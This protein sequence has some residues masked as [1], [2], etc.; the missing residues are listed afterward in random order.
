M[1]CIPEGKGMGAGGNLP[2]VSHSF[3]WSCGPDRTAFPDRIPT[4]PGENPAVFQGS[5][6][7][8]A[9]SLSQ[10]KRSSQ[11]L[12]SLCRTSCCCFPGLRL[13]R[14][15]IRLENT[16]C[17]DKSTWN[18]LL[19]WGRLCPLAELEHRRVWVYF[20]LQGLLGR[21]KW[22]I[23]PPQVCVV[24]KSGSVLPVLWVLRLECFT[25]GLGLVFRGDQ[26]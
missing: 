21:G 13:P 12:W 9:A 23:F 24:S 26:L 14:G 4:W 19:G 7:L 18:C 11:D 8:P 6:T 1:T 20:P 15:T 5:G 25:Q 16:S 3:A 22:E 2:F 10:G 17:Q